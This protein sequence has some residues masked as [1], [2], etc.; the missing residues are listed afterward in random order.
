MLAMDEKL[1][2]RFEAIKRF[3]LREGRMPSYSEMAEIFG[4]NSKNAVFKVVN[5]LVNS[6]L[7]KKDKKGRVSLR[8]SPFSI[9]VLGYVEAGF[10]SPAEEELLDKISLERFL[11]KNPNSTFMLKISGDSMIE[12]G[13][14]PGDFVLVDRSLK[15]KVGDIV[16]AR[17]DGDWTVKYLRKKDNRLILVPANKNYKTIVPEEELY[18]AGVVIGVVRKYR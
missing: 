2:A 1:L 3:Y 18:I 11:I 15:P 7:L 8:E 17:V 5:K 4:F 16:I 14:L 10:P 13:I 9:G 6:G 12:A